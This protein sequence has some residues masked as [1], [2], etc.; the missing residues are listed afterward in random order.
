MCAVSTRL[1]C[2]SAEAVGGGMVGGGAPCWEWL[3]ASAS[4]ISPHSLLPTDPEPANL[5]VLI[6]FFLQ[7]KNQEKKEEAR[8]PVL[9]IPFLHCK[10]A[11]KR[12]VFALSSFSYRSPGRNAWEH[13]FMP[14]W[15]E[16]IWPLPGCVI[17][18]SIWIHLTT[19]HRGPR[20]E[21]PSIMLYSVTIYSEAF[22]LP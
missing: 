19:G 16:I 18:R 12:L 14:G 8:T 13:G 6:L 7:E 2:C 5:R 10:Y 20:T 9:V 11:A 1:Q 21:G 4:G 22:L 15:N 17:T 3:S